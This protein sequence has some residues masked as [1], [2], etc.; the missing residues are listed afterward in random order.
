MQ[1]GEAFAKLGYRLDAPRLDWSA[2]NSTGVCITLWRSE[3]DWKSLVMDS[4]IH[5]NPIE[6]WRSLPGNSKRIKHARRAQ[7]DFE[8]K[9]DVIVVDGTPGQGVTKATP[10]VPSDRK[11]LIWRV[12]HLDELDG[13]IRLEA[14]AE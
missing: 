3:I 9:V 5:A 7:Q 12:T 4:R 6:E 10:W 14:K 2:E 13:H 8:G 1:Y 11:G